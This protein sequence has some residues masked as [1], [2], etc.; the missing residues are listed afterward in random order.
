MTPDETDT[1]L[2]LFKRTR[3]IESG[4]KL[5]TSDIF[6]KQNESQGFDMK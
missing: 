1:N 5:L 4:K 2:L 3:Y 6:V